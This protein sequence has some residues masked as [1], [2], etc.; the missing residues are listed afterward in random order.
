MRSADPSDFDEGDDLLII[1]PSKPAVTGRIDMSA[2]ATT[3]AGATLQARPDRALLAN[4]LVYVTLNSLAA[5]F[6]VAGAGRVAIVD[7]AA[8]TV[9]GVIDLPDQT[10]CSGLAYVEATKRLYVSCGGATSDA[11][12]TAK[13][14]LV[15]IDLS[16]AT[17]ALGKIIPAK[18]L[19][20]QP[21]T[22]LSVVVLRGIAYVGTAGAL[23]FKTNM[24]TAP[25]SLFAITLDTGTPTKVIDGGAYNLGRFALDP[26]SKALLLPNADAVT[27]RIHIFDVSTDTAVEG[28]MFEAN[29]AEHLPPREIAAY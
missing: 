29:P 28:T 21:L 20:T 10:G 14:A 2:H 15:E 6:S 22:Y 23:D 12:Q 26:T 9:A 18:S 7:P 8:D 24:M 16:G 27:P 17:P 25:D 3:V 1:D 11:D 5:D 13:S 4:G 19:G